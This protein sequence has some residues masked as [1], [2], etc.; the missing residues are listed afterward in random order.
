MIAVAQPCSD[1]AMGAPESDIVRKFQVLVAELEPLIPGK[2]SLPGKRE[3]ELMQTLAC[4][5]HPSALRVL[6]PA[7]AF[8]LNPDVSNEFRT[9]EEMIP[10]MG[11]IKKYFG[12][13]ALSTLFEAGMGAEKSWLQRRIAETVRRIAC[14]E[15]VS[16]LKRRYKNELQQTA[17]GRSFAE[18]LEA[19]EIKLKLYRPNQELHD[20]LDR[21]LKSPKSVDDI[22]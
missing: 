12:K 21:K 14:A 17:E 7:L 18:L 5:A 4:T 9:M 13:Q 8:N 6:I 19:P 16:E 3:L 11:L 20:R 2:P 10:A 15:D 1:D 22:G